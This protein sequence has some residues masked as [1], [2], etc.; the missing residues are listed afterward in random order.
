MDMCF[1]YGKTIII[2][3]ELLK[4]MVSSPFPTRA[5]VSDVYNSVMLRTDCVMLSDET[6]IGQF[7]IQ[8]CQMMH[9]I[10]VEAE[11]HT[12]NKHKDFEITFVDNYAIDK[13]MIAKNALF[14]ADE[15]KADYILLFTNS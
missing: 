2:A 5:E 10:V 12:N 6:A 1:K 9:D 14:I 11:S 15:I 8:A 4:S 3:T 13:K 7:P